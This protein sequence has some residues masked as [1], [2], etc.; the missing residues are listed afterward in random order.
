MLLRSN[1]ALSMIALVS[2][3]GGGGGDS[4]GNSAEISPISAFG[5]A[6]AERPQDGSFDY[7]IKDTIRTLGSVDGELSQERQDIDLSGTIGAGDITLVLDGETYVLERDAIDP[8]IATFD[9]GGDFVQL[10]TTIGENNQAVGVN[11]FSVIDGELNDGKLVLGLDTNP[12]DV[13]MITGSA[14]YTGRAEAT[15][16]NGFSSASAGGDLNLTVDFDDNSVGGTAELEFIEGSLDFDPVTIAFDD[17]DLVGNGFAGNVSIE[18]GD[19]G[20]TLDN[21]TYEGR[22]FGADAG[23]VGGT[24][25]GQ[26]N[27]DDSDSNTFVDGVFIGAE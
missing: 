18:A 19:I 12:N 2:A 15:L 10:S 17:T 26:I 8:S 4:G 13:E 21:T 20:G 7:N 23:T 27:L 24:F 25:T 6:D 22:L 5:F 14:D 9:D 16:R 1:L 11:I 3:C